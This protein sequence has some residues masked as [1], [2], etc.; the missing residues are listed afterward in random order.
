[1]AVIGL[2]TAFL[3]L[4]FPG[5]HLHAEARPVCWDE[6]L[7]DVCDAGRVTQMMARRSKRRS[8]Q[9]YLG[10][11]RGVQYAWMMYDESHPL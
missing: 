7:A 8:S 6:S 11:R 5:P 4:T 3:I 1:M 9:L 10:K 2:E